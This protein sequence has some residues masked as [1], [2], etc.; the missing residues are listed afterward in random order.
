MLCF[1]VTPTLKFALLPYCRRCVILE[2]RINMN[3]LKCNH[4]NIFSL[5]KSFFL[6]MLELPNF[7]HM[8]KITIKFQLL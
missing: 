4:A 8:R 2:I 6:E 1:L 5:K 3:G 7:G